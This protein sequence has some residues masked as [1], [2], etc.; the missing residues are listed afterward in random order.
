MVPPNARLHFE[1]TLV[2]HQMGPA[3]DVFGTI[4]GNDDELVSIKEYLLHRFSEIDS[5]VNE[6]D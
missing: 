5:E 2:H 4:D 3:T 6:F 1:L